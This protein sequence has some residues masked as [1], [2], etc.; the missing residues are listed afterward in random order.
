MEAPSYYRMKTAQSLGVQ[1][2]SQKASRMKL[3]PE[4]LALIEKARAEDEKSG[5]ADELVK[6]FNAAY[7]DITDK[8]NK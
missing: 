2:G 7:D 3:S 8:R 5:E 1:A 4:L 6:A